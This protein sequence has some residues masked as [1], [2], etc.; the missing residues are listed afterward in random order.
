MASVGL[1][2][3]KISFHFVLSSSRRYVKSKASVKKKDLKQTFKLESLSYWIEE[4]K[5]RGR[6]RGE[7]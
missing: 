2:F 5:G 1:E 3:F 6:C 7:G 4:E